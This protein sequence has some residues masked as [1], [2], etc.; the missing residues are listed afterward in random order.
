M[1]EKIERVVEKVA[2]TAFVTSKIEQN[3]IQT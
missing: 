1:D 2:V 3:R